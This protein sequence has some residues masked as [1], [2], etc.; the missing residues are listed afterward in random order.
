MNADKKAKK[1]APEQRRLARSPKCARCRNHGVVSCLKGHKRF[2]RWRDCQCTNCLLV[3]ERQRVMAAQ[4]ALRRQQA[5]EVKKGVNCK[6]STAPVRRTSYQRYPRMPS[7]LAKS[8]LEGYRPRQ[9]DNFSCPNRFVL[10]PLSDRMRKRRAFADKELESVMLEREY[11]E[12]ELQEFTAV[13]AFTRPC[14]ETVPEYNLLRF[15]YNQFLDPSQLNPSTSRELLNFYIPLVHTN[16]ALW[17]FGTQCY[18]GNIEQSRGSHSANMAGCISE[19]ASGYTSVWGQKSTAVNNS[20]YSNSTHNH[21]NLPEQLDPMQKILSNGKLT[22]KELCSGHRDYCTQA[23]ITNNIDSTYESP[24][25]LLSQKKTA[26][27]IGLSEKHILLKNYLTPDSQVVPELRSK[28]APHSFI[29]RETL[30]Q[31]AKKTQD[32]CSSSQVRITK[33]LLP[34]SVESLLKT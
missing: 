19:Q 15:S 33:Q 5:T 24:A 2:C 6:E 34:F 7:L 25:V 13:Q 27:H 4:V 16:P 12:R 20:F 22:A 1:P 14:V 11:R 31:F 9:D 8:I 3:V 32:H 18:Q 17:D 30:R 10:P 28:S 23:K 29:A 21:S 26:E